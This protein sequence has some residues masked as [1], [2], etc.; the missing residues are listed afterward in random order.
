MQP[1]NKYASLEQVIIDALMEDF[2][3]KLPE[4]EISNF[5]L[6]RL[7][8]QQDVINKLKAEYRELIEE[9]RG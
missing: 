2:P 9:S 7:L 3:N 8:G 6:G 5:E 4:K 1:H